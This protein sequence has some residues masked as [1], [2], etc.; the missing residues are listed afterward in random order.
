MTDVVA[1]GG[2]VGKGAEWRHQHRPD[3][4]KKRKGDGQNVIDPRPPSRLI[5]QGAFVGKGAEWRHQHRPAAG[6]H[7]LRESDSA[8]PHNLRESDSKAVTRLHVLMEKGQ[9]GGTST[10]LPST[11]S[12]LFLVIKIKLTRLWVN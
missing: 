2:E 6:P 4:Q 9:N 10:I 7:N 1:R 8:G 12:S 11:Y 5:G 3:G